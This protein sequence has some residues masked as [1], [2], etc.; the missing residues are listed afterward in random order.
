MKSAPPKAYRYS[1]IQG[2]RDLITGREGSGGASAAEIEQAEAAVLAGEMAAAPAPDCTLQHIDFSGEIAGTTGL[3][4]AFLASSLPRFTA[5][6]QLVLI[7]LMTHALAR[8]VN[9]C[10][11]SVAELRD[12]TRLTNYRI[13][14]ALARLA[15]SGA[16]H[17]LHRN[18]AGTLYHMEIIDEYAS[19]QAQ[20]PSQK[21]K[22]KRGAKNVESM[23]SQY[24]IKSAPTERLDARVLEK[25]LGLP[26]PATAS[27]AAAARAIATILE[28]YER[29]AHA[30][31]DELAQRSQRSDTR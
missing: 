11:L 26:D 29:V 3:P 19:Q 20:V 8:G 16:I 22:S 25:Y 5:E 9:F 30:S 7:H 31:A 17:L 24:S 10:R 1:P 12:M 15:E 13:Q 6:E 27:P 2:S 14:K 23:K 18:V 21:R 4:A 28:A